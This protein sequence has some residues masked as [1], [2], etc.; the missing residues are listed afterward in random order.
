MFENIRNYW[1]LKRFG[2]VVVVSFW[3]VVAKMKPQNGN[4]HDIFGAPFSG[5]PSHHRQVWTWTCK[6]APVQNILSFRVSFFLGLELGISSLTTSSFHLRF[7]IDWLH[8]CN[9][10][11]NKF[12]CFVCSRVLKPPGGGTSDLFTPVNGEEEKR[13]PQSISPSNQ[14]SSVSNGVEKHGKTFFFFFKFSLGY[15]LAFPNFP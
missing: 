12:F 1:S 4:S 8:K 14:E 5:T 15:F 9:K 10:W 13:I 3:F 2:Q 6:F 11:S 7:S